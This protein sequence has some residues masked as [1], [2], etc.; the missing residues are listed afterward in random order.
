MSRGPLPI[1][2]KNCAFCGE[3]FEYKLERAEMCRKCF[4]EYHN[5][6]VWTMNHLDYKL[7]DFADS[8]EE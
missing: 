6:Y 1:K 3:L 5:L 7:S 4:K 8:K 2:I